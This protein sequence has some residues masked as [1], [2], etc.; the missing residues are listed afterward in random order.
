MAGEKVFAAMGPNGPCKPQVSCSYR[1][2]IESTLNVALPQVIPGGCAV[3]QTL[4][5][6]AC[7]AT[8]HSRVVMVCATWLATI[9]A[10][11][12]LRLSTKMAFDFWGIPAWLARLARSGPQGTR[13]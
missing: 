5:I 7:D 8:L 9:N 11:S 10:R 6:S 4:V 2:P 3:G 1:E 13:Y 12:Y